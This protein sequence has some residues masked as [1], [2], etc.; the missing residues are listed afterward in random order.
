MKEFFLSIFIAISSFFGFNKEEPNIDSIEITPVITESIIKEEIIDISTEISPSPTIAKIKPTSTPKTPDLI[1]EEV[2]KV[3]FNISNVSEIN[4]ILENK[5]KISEYEKYY[6]EKFKNFPIPRLSIIS[7]K[8]YALPSKN[9]SVVC[10]SDQLKEI[11]NELSKFEEEIFYQEMDFKC[12]YGHT[13]EQESK[14]CQ[15]WRRDN[16]QNRQNSDNSL[17]EQIQEAKEE[18]HKK[19]NIWNLLV[20]KYCK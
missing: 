11:Y 2:L 3:F 17:D 14:E 8:L 12:H 4:K 13:S 16:D 18:R 20:E 1:T 19:D 15:D 5:D 7:N 6:Y 9:E 10:K